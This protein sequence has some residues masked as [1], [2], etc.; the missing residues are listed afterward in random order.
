LAKELNEKAMVQ[1]REAVERMNQQAMTQLKQGQQP[2]SPT[3]QSFSYQQAESPSFKYEQSRYPRLSDLASQ[4]PQGAV[5][6]IFFKQGFQSNLPTIDDPFKPEVEE[7]MK[8]FADMEEVERN[9]SHIDP[10]DPN[11]LKWLGSLEK[12]QV[13]E[14][15]ALPIYLSYPAPV[16]FSAPRF[17]FYF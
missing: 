1:Q 13:I 9:M 15:L 12:K 3:K 7:S 11:C 16:E 6:P 10:A 5:P 2:P 4:Y 17:D 8:R 14:V